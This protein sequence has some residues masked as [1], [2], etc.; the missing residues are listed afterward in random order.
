M[1][2]D[3]LARRCSNEQQ[4]YQKEIYNMELKQTYIFLPSTLRK[5]SGTRPALQA[6]WVLP[7]RANF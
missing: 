1:F 6:V 2:I 4:E 3:H 7:I 5:A